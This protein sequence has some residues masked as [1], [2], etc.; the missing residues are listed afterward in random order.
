MVVI[1]DRYSTKYKLTCSHCNSLLGVSDDDLTR[2]GVF[3]DEY[4]WCCP[5]CHHKNVF[6]KKE[7]EIQQKYALK[8]LMDMYS[9]NNVKFE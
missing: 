5:L 4:E 9:I 1:E 3:D 2:I 7:Y 6:D 8:E